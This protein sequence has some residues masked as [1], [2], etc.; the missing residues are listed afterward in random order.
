MH[1]TIE[2]KGETLH[3]LPD[4]AIHYPAEDAVLIGDL[5]WGKAATFRAAGMPVPDTEVDSDLD[6]ISRLLDR[7]GASR[8]IVLG[9]LL[10]SR[11]GRDE[12]TFA[13]VTRWRDTH[14]GIE[15][16]L[17]EG[18]HDR[19]AGRPPAE[20][21]FAVMKPGVR[22]GPFVLQHY[23]DPHGDGYV[24]AG[25]LHPKVKLRGVAGQEAKLPCF[26]FGEEVGVVPAFGTLIDGAPVKPR[27]RDA[28]FVVAD[29]EVLDVSVRN[30]VAAVR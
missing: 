6:R 4:H 23:P 29:G 30:E 14:P 21:G 8:L 10:H 12:Q 22:L 20:W 1:A 25:H 17:V 11:R 3:L 5:H 28:V 27:P 16:T 7:T 19:G 15:L 18:N 9:D 2:I 24:L 13:A 26:W